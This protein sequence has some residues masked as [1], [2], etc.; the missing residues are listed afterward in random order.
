ECSG[1]HPFEE[2]VTKIIPSVISF[3]LGYEDAERPN[4]FFGTA[5]GISLY[6]KNGL[7]DVF[8]TCS[9][10]FDNLMAELNESRDKTKFVSLFD[11]DRF[12]WKKIETVKRLAPYKITGDF[13]E[14]DLAETH[15]ISLCRV[16][17]TNVPPLTLSDDKYIYGAEVGILGFPNYE[18]LQNLD[19][20]PQILKTIISGELIYPI[21]TIKGQVN[22]DRLAL[23]CV[24][25]HGFSGSPVFSIETGHI[26]G[27]HDYAPI[28]KDIW[29]KREREP[30]NRDTDVYVEYPGGLSFAVPSTRLR[31]ALD[32]FE[33]HCYRDDVRRFL[34]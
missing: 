26:V 12:T 27:M 32:L 8:L 5:F 4:Q 22:T 9:H 15:D 25:G 28:E 14:G 30:Q 20:Q 31:Q 24:T 10:V 17:G 7:T 21:E 3:A 23:G 34:R 18:H 11:D 33:T 29:E 2:F 1:S 13:A 16:P 6:H 19:P